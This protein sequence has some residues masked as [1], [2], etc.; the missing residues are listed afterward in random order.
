VIAQGATLIVLDDFIVKAQPSLERALVARFGLND[1]MDAAAEAMAYAC[2]HWDR[3]STM[4]NPVGYL[5]RV[6][7][8]RT[9][10]EF[11][12][13]HR[14]FALVVEPLTTDQP[15]DIDL[16]RALMRVKPNQ[17]V[18]IVLVHSHGHSYAEAARLMDLPVT[19][20]ANHLTRGLA[21]LRRIL[22]A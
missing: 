10:R 15:V 21:S 6:G 2:T 18:A 14:T 11:Q 19:A 8:S 5:Y 3:I 20:V 22:E 1:G 4:A 7:E 9:R 17:R 13:A 16:Q 12:R